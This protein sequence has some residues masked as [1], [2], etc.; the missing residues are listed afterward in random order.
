MEQYQLIALG[1]VAKIMGYE[2]DVDDAGKPGHW[3]VFRRLPQWNEWNPYYSEND[4]FE[5]VRKMGM[6]IDFQR[7]RISKKIDGAGEMDCWWKDDGSYSFNEAVMTLAKNIID[8]K[9]KIL[10]RGHNPSG[11]QE[12]KMWMDEVEDSRQ[13]MKDQGLIP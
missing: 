8:D 11:G 3:T 4:A 12:P 2:F 5:V 1:N 6:T 13:Y 10:Y 9:R 7:G